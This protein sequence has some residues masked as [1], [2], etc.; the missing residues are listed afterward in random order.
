M[1]RTRFLYRPG[2]P[3]ANER[4]F[5]DAALEHEQIDQHVPVFTDAYMDGDRAPDGSDIGSRTKRKTWM[6]ATNS[7]DLSDFK[8]TGE[9]ARKKR[10]EYFTTGGDHKERRELV[11]RALHANRMGR[12]LE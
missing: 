11:G 2:H 3:L 10:E 8:E 5:V 6:K 1:S 9:K 4:G 12:K 7:A